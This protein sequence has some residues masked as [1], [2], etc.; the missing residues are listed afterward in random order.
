MLCCEEKIILLSSRFDTLGNENRGEL[1]N[2]LL[3]EK[4]QITTNNHKITPR[5][6]QKPILEYTGGK[7]AVPAVPGAGKTTIMLALIIK[8]IERGA[9]PSEILVLTYMESA[10]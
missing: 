9:N 1:L 5:E 3:P 2:F 6:D 8:L 7:M 4:S 10:A